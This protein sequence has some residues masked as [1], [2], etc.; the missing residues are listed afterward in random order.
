MVQR[1]D[2]PNNSR[3]LDDLELIELTEALAAIKNRKAAGLDG[4]NAELWKYGG[5]IQV[6]NRGYYFNFM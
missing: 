4:I 3:G 6:N 5:P 2:Q 1:K